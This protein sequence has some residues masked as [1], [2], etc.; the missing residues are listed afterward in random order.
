MKLTYG[1]I[2][3]AFLGLTALDHDDIKLSGETHMSVAINLNAFKPYTIAYEKARFRTL[4]DLNERNRGLPE[5]D[6]RSDAELQADFA[7]AD[8]AMRDK[9][10]EV[11]EARKILKSDLRMSD[12]AK[13]RGGT[14]ARL[15]PL[16]DG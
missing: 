11:N 7:D 9:E 4:A 13:I 14:I 1:Q 5:K 10:V 8:L 16:L 15:M 6:R 12:N 3:E 2:H